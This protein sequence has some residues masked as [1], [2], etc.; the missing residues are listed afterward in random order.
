M[1]CG[2]MWTLGIPFSQATDSPPCT[3]LIHWGAVTHIYVSKIII[4][5]WDNGLSTDR[6]QTIIRTHAGIMLIGLLGINFNV[7][8]IGI[9]TF[10]YKKVHLIMSSAK[11]TLFRLGLN[12]LTAGICLSLELCSETVKQFNIALVSSVF[13]VPSLTLVGLNSGTSGFLGCR[14]EIAS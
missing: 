4:T 2:F 7:I 3:A 12:E 6:R 9:H 10:S 5:G 11:W 8:L 14:Q 13:W 1:D